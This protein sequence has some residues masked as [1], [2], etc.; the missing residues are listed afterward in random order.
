MADV[1]AQSVSV[2]AGA[3]PEVS[4]PEPKGLS[5]LVGRQNGAPAMDVFCRPLTGARDIKGPTTPCLRTGL[6]SAAPL[7]LRRSGSFAGTADLVELL[8]TGT[9]TKERFH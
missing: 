4:G 8:L 3:V 5:E 1:A 7:A 2:R 9:R 6:P